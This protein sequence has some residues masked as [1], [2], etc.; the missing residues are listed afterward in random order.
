[1]ATPEQPSPPALA[2]KI[3]ISLRAVGDAPQL[4]HKR[5]AVEGD[6]TISWVV[7]WLEKNLKC[8]EGET[9]V[10]HMTRISLGINLT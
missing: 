4:K 2:E 6:R 3:V 9:L 10:S 1:M 7:K 5:F 8:G